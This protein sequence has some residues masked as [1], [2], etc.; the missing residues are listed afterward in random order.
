MTRERNEGGRRDAWGVDFFY[1]IG[2]TGAAAEVL[3]R[4]L[5]QNRQAFATF[6]G[7]E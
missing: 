7:A 1:L 2:T 5:R 6:C 3:R 4:F